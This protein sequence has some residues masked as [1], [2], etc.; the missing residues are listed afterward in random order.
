MERAPAGAEVIDQRVPEGL[1]VSA[2]QCRIQAVLGGLAGEHRRFHQP[3]HWDYDCLFELCLDFSDLNNS[4][5][6]LDAYVF[7]GVC[8]KLGK[9]SR[10]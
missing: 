9:I 1:F 5:M 7:V 3:P 6:I 8:H 2:G 10:N 4:E